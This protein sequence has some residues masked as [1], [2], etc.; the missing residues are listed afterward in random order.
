MVNEDAENDSASSEELQ[1]QQLL[2]NAPDLNRL[3]SME[4][5]TNIGA[6]SAIALAFA[7][8]SSVIY[9]PVL[10]SGANFF[11]G[12]ITV[13]FE[14][15]CKF[16]QEEIHAGRF[17]L[18]NPLSY[19][20]MPQ[21]AITSPS[22]LYG[23]NWLFVLLPFSPALALIMIAHQA[24]SGVGGFLLLKR[25]SVRDVSAIAGGATIALNGYMFT[26]ATNFTLVESAAWCPVALWALLSCKQAQPGRFFA[27]TLK[28]ALS[29]AMLL[30]AGRPE[31]WVPMYVFLAS[32]LAYEFVKSRRSRLKENSDAAWFAWAVRGMFIGTAL[33]LPALLPAAEWLGLSRRSLGLLPAEVLL[34]SA[35]WT[36]LLTMIIGLP[37]GDPRHFSFPLQNLFSGVNQPP[38]LACSYL[39]PVCVTIALCAM[40][41]KKFR[42]RTLL[43]SLTILVLIFALGNNTPFIPLLAPLLP[44]ISIFRFPVKLLF[45]VAFLCS[46]MVAFGV[47]SLLDRRMNIRAAIILWSGLLVLGIWFLLKAPGL[48]PAAI[49][50]MAGINTSGMSI[51]QIQGL[52]N[53]FVSQL[54][55]TLLLVSTIGVL[56]CAAVAA[57]GHDDITKQTN[58]SCKKV[59][60]VMTA[61][62]T[63]SLLLHAW[64]YE[65][66]YASSDFFRR[67]SWTAK[68]I[69]FYE[70]MQPSR[71]APRILCLA[72][73]GLSI[74]QQYL[75][76]AKTRTELTAQVSQYARQLLKPNTNIDFG[77]RSSFGFESAMKGDYYN[78]F[79]D[80][81]G[82]SSQ[83]W[84]KQEES[85]DLTDDT[86]L[87]RFC[88]LSAVKYVVTQSWAQ[89]VSNSNA[90]LLPRLDPALFYLSCE[91]KGMNIR[92]YTLKTQL[93]RV[94]LSTNWKVL[95][96]HRAAM[97]EILQSAKSHGDPAECT[98]LEN[99]DTAPN[100]EPQTYQDSSF[101]HSSHAESA[102]P[103]RDLAFLEE[104]PTY[105]KVALTTNKQVLLVESDQ[106]YPG[107]SAKLD[108]KD[109]VL[110]VANGCMRAVIVPPGE[111]TVEIEY[112]PRSFYLGLAL[113]ALALGL[114]FYLRILDRRTGQIA[115]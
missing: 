91:S 12:D 23:P 33:A 108:K 32:V 45:F 109:A 69:A 43:F 46:I 41:D 113:A 73:G 54:G 51:A 115:I 63:I 27:A 20:G 93:P 53:D 83:F 40:A 6:L 75:D 79:A 5:S 96:S 114:A 1:A 44:L 26:A 52:V 100:V 86:A 61:A 97:D 38:Y 7:C 72:L 66:L 47:E 15:L 49:A 106:H 110:L 68:T 56:A 16:L 76:E 17:P 112:R 48:T 39:G 70:Q 55:I 60:N 87:Y 59:A 58:S 42:Y 85:N 50:G 37:W 90:V 2:G 30:L 92:I 102:T 10:F 71:T 18:W 11:C 74:P 95:P 65:R 80:A 22:L 34:Y 98:V 36:Q 28:L 3:Q 88:Q 4:S 82:C 31:I 101:Q 111:H 9:A 67:S 24:L 107:W 81:Y 14:P 84:L 8:L 13:F 21:I 25:L 78:L 103:A 77:I 89:A 64:T 19:C 105:L 104:S 29:V 35:T 99:L 94:Y 57:A 62:I